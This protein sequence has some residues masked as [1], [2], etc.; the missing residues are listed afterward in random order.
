VDVELRLADTVGVSTARQREQLS[1]DDVAIEAI[2]ALPVGDSYCY[3][4][5]ADHGHELILRGLPPI[6]AVPLTHD[7]HREG[8]RPLRRTPSP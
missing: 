4:V 1:A 5:D 3:V 8:V 6:D 7:H 2:R